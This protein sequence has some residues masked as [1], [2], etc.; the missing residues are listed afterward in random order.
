MIAITKSM[1]ALSAALSAG[2]VTAYDA[3]TARTEPQPAAQIA[4]RFPA[5]TEMFTVLPAKPAGIVSKSDRAPLASEGC[6]RQDWPYI[7]QSCLVSVDGKPVRKV[8]RI[9]TVERRIDD[10]SS[11][12]S[13]VPVTTVANR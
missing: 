4:Q 9:I 1:I 5:A 12:L 13:R 3:A 6:T 8:S 11:E 7:A 10:S 2:L